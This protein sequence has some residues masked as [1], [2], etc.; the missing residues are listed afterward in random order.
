[1]PQCSATAC[2]MPRF[3]LPDDEAEGSSEG[4]S[5]DEEEQAALDAEGAAQEDE[6]AA[7]GA[8]PSAT[9]ERPKISL[10]LGQGKVTCHVSTSLPS[11]RSQALQRAVVAAV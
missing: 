8:G 5:A 10:K 7:E 11:L 2:V 1:M 4:E 6:D 9:A 3:A